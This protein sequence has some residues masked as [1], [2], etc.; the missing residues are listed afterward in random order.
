MHLLLTA[1]LRQEIQEEIINVKKDYHKNKLKKSVEVNQQ[2]KEEEARS[3]MFNE[4]KQEYD[5]YK[6]KKE[7]LPKKGAG[8]EQFTLNLLEK[9]KEKLHSA[10]EDESSEKGESDEDID[11]EKSL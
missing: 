6:S 11:N 8:R 2:V 3:E 5:K 7:S 10:K 1:V 4:Y 9:F